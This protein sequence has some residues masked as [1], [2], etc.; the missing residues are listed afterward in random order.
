MMNNEDLQRKM[1]FIVE[2]QAQFAAD[3]QKLQ[4]SQ[5]RTD[6]VVSQSGQLL[7]RTLEIVA[8]SGEM[9]TRLANVTEQGFR[10]TLEGFKDVNAK[11]DA[12]VDA[13]LRTETNL[14][15]TDANVARTDANVARTDEDLRS[16]IA[17]VDRHLREG[18][19]GK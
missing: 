1:D 14:A 15:R 19:D 12:L 9:I 5:A 18:R 3:I 17:S 11:I 2:Q 13:Q 16:L 8:Q 4:E 10:V 7:A 6:Q